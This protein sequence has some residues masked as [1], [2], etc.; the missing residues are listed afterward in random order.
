MSIIEA[1]REVEGTIAVCDVCGKELAGFNDDSR[2][3]DGDEC[4]FCGRDI[5]H[6]CTNWCDI[7]DLN[8]EWLG[9]DGNNICCGDC[10]KKGKEYIKIIDKA[11]NVATRAFYDWIKETM[12]EGY[13]VL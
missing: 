7:S 1:K 5:C 4:C 11:K 12:E 9:E 2:Y 3:E 10:Y 6:T 13:S 8:L